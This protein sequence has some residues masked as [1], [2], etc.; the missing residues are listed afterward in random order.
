MSPGVLGALGAPGG[1]LEAPGGFAKMAIDGAGSARALTFY[2]GC[3]FTS[4]SF[5][6]EQ[7]LW[8]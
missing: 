5:Q 6:R 7:V 8:G 3:F 4:I 2:C 1:H